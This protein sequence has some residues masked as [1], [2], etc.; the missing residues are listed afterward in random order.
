MI[1]LILP[2]SSSTGQ[3]T[4]PL[5]ALF[6]A[7]SAVSVT[8][9]IVVDTGTY[10][11]VFGQGVLLALF[12]I[13]GLGFITGATVLLMAFA[14]RFGLRE[15]LV[16]TEAMG[17]D[18]LGGLLGVVAKVAVFSLIIEAAGA[19]VLYFQS[20]A[21]GYED[22]SLWKSVFQSVSAFN[23]C[24]L[25]ILGGVNSL[26]GFR[27]NTLFLLI[28]ALL[29]ILGSTGYVVIADMINKRRFY[30]LSLDSKI[31]LMITLALL[32][33]GTIFIFGS[34]YSNQATL[35]QLS[36]PQKLG[37]AFFQAIVPRTAGFTALDIAN[38]KSI[39]IF[40]VLFLMFIGGA[41]GSTAGGLK[42]NTLGVLILTVVSTVRGKTRPEA[43]G[44]QL[45]TE[46]VYRAITFFLFYLGIA[47]LV[48][49][50]LSITEDF[51]IDKLFFET[52]SAL[53]T[54][55]LSTG[56][57]TEL[58]VAGRLM[59]VIAMFIGRLGPLL[60]MA[61][62]GRRRPVIDIEYPHETI[63]MG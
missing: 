37:V 53:S 24:G 18:R 51:P 28:T 42:V 23:N 50:I 25:D 20:L 26:S 8:G 56:I 1:L 55:G 16:I 14:G 39:T 31:V 32:L 11:S 45:T 17:L 52:F 47:G 5:T 9:L 36:L 3:F 44:R 63:R 38:L 62:L 29:V 27:E 35:G 59:L 13:G 46:T 30:K 49:L 61:T 15:R 40:F 10:W 60:L 22:I 54:V 57:T 19:A 58:S 34:E 12:Q 2:I 43:F 33:L 48:I 4:S 41:A 7:T 21:S 6:T